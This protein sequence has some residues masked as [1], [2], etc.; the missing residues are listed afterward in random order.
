MMRVLE[1]ENFV[2]DYDKEKRIYRV[3]YFENGHYKDEVCFDA[4][5]DSSKDFPRCSVGDK[6]WYTYFRKEPELCTVSMLQ[7]KKDKS[8]K[9]RL[10]PPTSGVFDITLERFNK[11]CFAK[12]EE[13]WKAMKL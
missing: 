5:R 13:A 9:V 12:E 3:S 1:N 7:Q 10:T 11:H 2:V 6:V 4:C 8:W